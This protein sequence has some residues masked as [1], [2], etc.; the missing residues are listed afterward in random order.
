MASALVRWLAGRTVDELAGVLAR[1]PDVLTG[2]TPTDLPTLADRLQSRG[3]VAAAL[4]ALPRPAV[5]VVEAAQAAGGPSVTTDRLAGLLGRTGDDPA[6][7]ATLAQL[8]DHALVWPDGTELRMAAPLWSAFPH[9]LGLG[10]PAEQLLAGLTT[11]ELRGIGRALGTTVGPGQRD[12]LTRI[13][14]VLADVDRVRAVVAG[15]PAPARELLTR[16][17]R[18]GPPLLAPDPGGDAAVDWALHRG[19]LVWDGWRHAQ[20]PAEVGLA[21]RG[22]G[23]HAP[24]DPD[25]PAPALVAVDPVAV[26]RETA[27]A[28]LG[29][30]ERVTALLAHLDTAP[31]TTLRAGGVGSR[32]LR[33]L[34]RATGADEAETRLWLELTHRAG[35]VGT[36]DDRVRPTPA[37]DRWLAAEPADRL[38]VLLR[39]WPRLPAAPLAP[40]R[41]GGGPPAPA[42]LPD[43][44]ALVAAD[45][46]AA[47]LHQAA[48]LPA[49]HGVGAGPGGL[50]GAVSWRHPLLGGT[51]DEARRDLL[52]S[53]W[54]EAG[55]LGVVAHGTL[56][57][58]GRALLDDPAGL[59]ATARD[60]LP[61]AVGEAVFQTDLTAVVPGLPR[62]R[63]AGLLDGAAVRESHGSA[64]TWRFTPASV[65]TALDAGAEPA[66]LLAGLRAVAVGGTLPQAL[67][68]LVTDVA[69]QHGRVTV[70]RVGCVLHVADPALATELCRA[71]ALR[72]LGLAVLA[73]TVLAAAADA[74]ETVRALRAAGYPPVTEDAGGR[75]QVDRPERPRAPQR[76]RD[77]PPP[78]PA[79]TP[80][81]LTAL[82]ARLL[83]ADAPTGHPDRVA[84]GEATGTLAAVRR[85][86]G[87]LD[88]EQ[89]R[90]L[91]V[92]VDQGSP[93]RIAYRNAAGKASDRV[94]EPF[95][96]DGH[97][98]VAWCRL[99]DDER[100]F[101]LP[102]IDAVSPA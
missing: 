14:A 87:H 73:P 57:R 10:E 59:D 38:P 70:R 19:L 29:A 15:A 65:R 62:A 74:E 51:D 32:E 75:R 26:D 50:T 11:E 30:V 34:A 45:L 56:S 4:A 39:A 55:L 25:P 1:R 46:R 48:V 64:T 28:A 77:D 35:L 82:A 60:L 52:A 18:T 40:G 94:V 90:A 63:L 102:R 13:C 88:A 3:S 97:L 2:P 58:L 96:L 66:A 100:I 47:L 12:L 89:Q 7:T 20:L 68:Y 21:L 42:L 71:R 24:F 22:P 16:L 85:H 27:A 23:W 98:L 36:D 78:T 93:V 54:R 49:G 80:S 95:D 67:E 101:A 31:A 41:T 44:T 5:Q 79:A 6:L 17:A 61:D 92:A 43:H 76:H 37:Y 86:A 53:L 99:R 81:D 33:R 8:A 72:P 83:A 69:R 91:A 9:P 84:P